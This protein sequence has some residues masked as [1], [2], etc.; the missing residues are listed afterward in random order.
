MASRFQYLVAQELAAVGGRKLTVAGTAMPPTLDTAIYAAAGVPAIPPPPTPPPAPPPVAPTDP[1]KGA[2]AVHKGDDLSEAVKALKAGGTLAL[3]RGGTWN[4]P[5][6]IGSDKDGCSVVAFGKGAMPTIQADFGLML[7]GPLDGFTVTGIGFVGT[8]K[9]KGHGVH[10]ITNQLHDLTIKSC[11]F[12][13]FMDNIVIQPL[14]GDAVKRTD[15]HTNVAIV[16]NILLASGGDGERDGQGM[17]LQ[18][19]DSLY[20]YENLILGAG[21]NRVMADGKTP[22]IGIYCHGI[23]GQHGM[24]RVR[25]LRNIFSHCESYG[26]QMRGPDALKMGED[27]VDPGATVADN[28]FHDCGIGFALTGSKGTATNNVTMNGHFHNGLWHHGQGGG[29]L[30]LGS[31][32]VTGNLRLGSDPP[33]KAKGEYVMPAFAFNADTP[34]PANNPWRW[35][36]KVNPTQSGNRDLPQVRYDPTTVINVLRLWDTA[37]DWNVGTVRDTIHNAVLKLL[38]A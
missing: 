19:I 15:Y 35:T 8:P 30:Y 21:M 13:G 17:F 22:A 33:D 34:D 14:A 5:L 32:T 7:Y 1:P 29:N 16:N 24:K 12:A 18:A 20:V 31:G 11:L 9:T 3:E 25:V 2:I 4:E 10:G 38:P 36:G 27:T 28:I 26:A 6:A 37:T 23:Y